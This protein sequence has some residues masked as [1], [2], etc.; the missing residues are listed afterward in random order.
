MIGALTRYSA[1]LLFL[2]LPVAVAQTEIASIT[3]PRVSRAPKLADFVTGTPREAECAVSDFRQMDPGDGDPVSRPT[4]AFLS[5]DDRNLYVAFVAKD[6][7]SLIRARIA[8]R[9]Q[10]LTDDRITINIDT[11]HDHR[12]AY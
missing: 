10:I 9:K 2:W 6:D 4:T 3:I 7:P 12:H 11:F 1:L 8:K 5:Y